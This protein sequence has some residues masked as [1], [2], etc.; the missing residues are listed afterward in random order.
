M[1]MK[2]DLARLQRRVV[3]VLVTE[4]TKF[5]DFIAQNVH[6]IVGARMSLGDEGHSATHIEGFSYALPLGPWHWAS[7][8]QLL[9]TC[10]GLL[11]FRGDAFSVPRAYVGG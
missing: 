4:L 5:F 1:H 3:D 2:L 6:P 11:C 9:G 7:V 8:A 10:Q